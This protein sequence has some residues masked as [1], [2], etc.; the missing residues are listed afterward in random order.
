MENWRDV[1][2]YTIHDF[3]IWHER[4]ELSLSPKYQ[5]NPVWK[6]EAKSYLIDTIL[7]GLTVPP[8]FLRQ[9]TNFALQKIEREIIDGQQR[10]RT[11][12]EFRNN[13]FAISKIH[14]QEY[15]N[16]FFDDLPNEAQDHFLNFSLATEIIRTT[17]DS[18][19][20]DIF[21]P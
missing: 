13:E 17:D 12:F 5:R 18:L 3:W 14:N 1:K 2:V 7:R 21:A 15:G 6:K 8:I 20:Y 11:I 4:G 10:L 16:L 19:V 9:Q